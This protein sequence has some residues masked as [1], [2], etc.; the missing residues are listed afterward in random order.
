MLLSFTVATLV[1]VTVAQ[2]DAGCSN[3][4]LAL[5]RAGGVAT[6]EACQL[7]LNFEACVSQVADASERSTL[8]IDLN[9]QQQQHAACGT[10]AP[11]TA[12]IRTSRDAMDFSGR[13]F[14]LVPPLP[15]ASNAKSPAH[16]KVLAEGG[17]LSRSGEPR[18][19]MAHLRVGG[20]APE[21][22]A[23]AR[24]P[25]RAPT[26]HARTEPHDRRQARC[27][28]LSTVPPS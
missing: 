8:E 26:R 12:S 4:L 6:P 18:G 22:L 3:E 24:A 17:S 1:G 11:L 15:Q 13:D 25:T 9:Q 2:A 19:S 23:R 5:Y 14:T 7:L 21:P 27:N 20:R 16:K 28:E 10:A